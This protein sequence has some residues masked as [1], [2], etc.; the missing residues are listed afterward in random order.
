MKSCFTTC[1]PNHGCKPFAIFAA[2]N[3]TSAAADV[4][5]KA[6]QLYEAKNYPEAFQKCSA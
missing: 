4:F 3:K 6:T 2:D 1:Q 5:A